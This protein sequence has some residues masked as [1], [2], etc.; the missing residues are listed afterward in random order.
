MD[1]ILSST[2]EHSREEGLTIEVTPKTTTNMIVLTKFLVAPYNLPTFKPKNESELV[3][4]IIFQ[5][6]LQVYQSFHIYGEYRTRSTTQCPLSQGGVLTLCKK[7]IILF[8]PKFTTFTSHLSDFETQ[9]ENI[10]I[11]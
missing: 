3:K 1:V 9:N 11:V 7:S 10:C 6:R 4:S 2:I 8:F 5:L